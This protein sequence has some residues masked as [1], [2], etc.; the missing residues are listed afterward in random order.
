MVFL[1]PILVIFFFSKIEKKKE[2]AVL[3]LWQKRAPKIVK[4]AKE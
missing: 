4:K 2:I 3:N 1:T